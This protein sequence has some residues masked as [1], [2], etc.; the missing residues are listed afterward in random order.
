MKVISKSAT[1]I[2]IWA[3]IVLFLLVSPASAQ[4]S[5]DSPAYEPIEFVDCPLDVV[6]QALA[7]ELDINYLIDPRLINWWQMPIPDSGMKWWETPIPDSSVAHLPIINFRANNITPR[8][9][10]EQILAEHHLILLEDPQTGVARITYPKQKIKTLDYIESVTNYETLPIQFV[11][12][13]LDLCFHTLARVAGI[14]YLIDPAVGYGRPDRYGKVQQPPTLTL[15]WDHVTAAQGFY[16]LSEN[17]G[18]TVERDPN[19]HIVFIRT[20]NH[21]I[22]PFT[23]TNF[24]AGDTNY[25]APATDALAPIQAE[26]VPLNVI[27]QAVAK[28]ANVAVEFDPSD[29]NLS[30]QT[31]SF[32]FTN[33]SPKQV[34][35][36]LCEN[37]NLN[38]T[39]DPKN[40]SIQI[41]A[42]DVRS[43]G[44]PLVP[45]PG[46][47]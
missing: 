26:Y 25:P 47:G 8:E 31:V 40:G 18:F 4:P 37:Y 6:I 38:L 35:V 10:L 43:S 30:L 2:A 33:V 34:L 1:V 29:D 5:T 14:N 11:D 32:R 36:A 16:A 46:K 20:P 19:S 15:R 41:G 42:Q 22:T 44:V 9:V 27:I 13:P 12:V 3:V 28:E 23:D 7:R 21:P 24:L 45:N 17:Y 39:V